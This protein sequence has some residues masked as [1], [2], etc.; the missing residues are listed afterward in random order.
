MSVD[1]LHVRKT[2]GTA[3]AEALRPV[4]QSFGII[5]HDHHTRLSDIP[6]DHQVFFFVRHPIPRFVSG[7]FS[8]LRFGLPRHHYPWNESEANAFGIFQKANDLAEALSASDPQRLMQARSA[9]RGI[10]HVKNT[11]GDWFDGAKELDERSDSILLIGLQ[12]KLNEDFERLKKLLKIPDTIAL[13]S[14]DKLAHRTPA[15]FD[16]SLSPLAEKNL[17]EWYAQDI[18]FYEHCMRL[19][20]ARGQR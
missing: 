1:F 9:M 11:Y 10:S 13:P 12:E 7:F 17:R 2:G 19:R 16:R 5:L 20:A 3:V 6:R 14:D 15:E 4:A 18:Q 8:R